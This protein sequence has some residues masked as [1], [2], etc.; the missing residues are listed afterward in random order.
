MKLRA[1]RAMQALQSLTH[2]TLPTTDV[3]GTGPAATAV[4]DML[5]NRLRRSSFD[6]GWI[7]LMFFSLSFWSRRGQVRSGQV[8]SGQLVPAVFS[9]L[10]SC[11]IYITT[12]L[13]C[14]LLFSDAPRAIAPRH[15]SAKYKIVLPASCVIKLR[16]CFIV[17]RAFGGGSD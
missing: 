3:S 12:T 17:Q 10:L 4:I 14:C 2:V 5:G 7:F 6:K 11:R 9:L 16:V 15:S 1:A 13:C 8:R